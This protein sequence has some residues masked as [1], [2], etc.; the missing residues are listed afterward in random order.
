MR[1]D[2]EVVI[3]V[4]RRQPE[5]DFLVVLRS[6]EKQG[7]WHLI[8]GGIEE[9]ESASQTAAREL[10]EETG[11]AAG[12]LEALP[13]ELGY[14]RPPEFGGAWVILHPFWVE[15]EAGWEPTLNE[16]HVDHRWCSASE[17]SDLLAYPEPRTALLYVAERLGVWT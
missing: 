14:R 10:E 1:T 4:T 7:Y 13:L 11:R 16:E 9:G 5:A 6:P 15:A 2:E 3:V 17:A 8:A 12:G